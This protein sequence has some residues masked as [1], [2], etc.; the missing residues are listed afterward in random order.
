MSYPLH[1]QQQPAAATAVG[2]G[3]VNVGDDAAT[4]AHNIT[5]VRL[6]ESDGVSAQLMM[7]IHYAAGSRSPVTSPRHHTQ[8]YGLA[9]E[10]QLEP[11]I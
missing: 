6:G 8:D 1:P 7:N 5:V 2:G 4:A 9:G 10:K 3:V 11:F